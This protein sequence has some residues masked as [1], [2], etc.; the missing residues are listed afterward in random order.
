MSKASETDEVLEKT[1]EFIFETE[2]DV[3]KSKFIAR[4]LNEKY[5]TDISPKM[6]GKRFQKIEDYLGIEDDEIRDAY[7]TGTSWKLKTL[8][9]DYGEKLRDLLE[10]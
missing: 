5:G 7:T 1:V 3:Y 2:K 4:R 8:R 6:V 9:D 10:D